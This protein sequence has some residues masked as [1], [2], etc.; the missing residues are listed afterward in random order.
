MNLIDYI[1]QIPD[2]PKPN[3]IFQDITPLLLNV[4]AFDACI[5]QLRK[6]VQHL[7]FNKIGII[8]ARGFIFG[9]ALAYAMQ[10]PFFPF[11]KANKLPF[12]TLTASYQLEYGTDT[13][14]M[15][16]DAV[17]ENDNIL[18]VDDVLATGGT[19]SAACELVKQ[20]GANITATLIL[21]E[22]TTLNGRSKIDI[23][24]CISLLKI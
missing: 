19:L 10:K 11:R 5:E 14:E 20:A 17:S 13:L 23:N 2:H 21:L 12:T 9:T 24:N 18:I 1:R 4:D 8:D 15:H 3:I 16:A 7:E 22:L 6:Q